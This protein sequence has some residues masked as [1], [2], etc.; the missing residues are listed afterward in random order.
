[1]SLQLWA[2]NILFG[3]VC[4]SL[5]SSSS[6]LRVFCHLFSFVSFVVKAF[7]LCCRNVQSSSSSCYIFHRAASFRIT[8]SGWIT[9]KKENVILKTLDRSWSTLYANVAPESK[10]S[11]FVI[12]IVETMQKQSSSSVMSEKKWNK[13]NTLTKF[14]WRIYL[15]L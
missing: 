7:Y 6:C 5:L 9:K 14:K 12:C 2:M 4:S 3:D 11:P 10:M 13:N 1:M 15:L 8:M